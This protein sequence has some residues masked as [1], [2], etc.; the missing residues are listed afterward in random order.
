MTATIDATD[1]EHFEDF[2][3]VLSTLRAIHH[4]EYLEPIQT[5]VYKA[6]AALVATKEKESGS[7][8][9]LTWLMRKGLVKRNERGKLVTEHD[10]I[11]LKVLI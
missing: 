3:K 6:L 4:G 1:F 9:P 5:P 2:L 8:G 7:T 11:E 10:R